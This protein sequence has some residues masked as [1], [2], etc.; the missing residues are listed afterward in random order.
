MNSHKSDGSGKNILMGNEMAGRLAGRYLIEN[1]CV[2][3]AVLLP[4]TLNPGL[5]SRIE[6]FRFEFFAN[7][8]SCNELEIPIR[9]QQKEL[10][11]CTDESLENAMEA[12]LSEERF[13]QYDG[14]FSPEERLTA[15]LYRALQ[16]RRVK[17]WPLIIS[18]NY[19]SEYLAGL[20]PRP[21]TI[22][23]GQRM[24]AELA[25]K[26]LLHRIS[27]ASKRDDNI[28]VIT[29]PKLVPGDRIL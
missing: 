29:T 15:F 13:Q 19:T 16:K 25:I 23:M 7:K 14:I 12:M 26:E 17:K 22:D 2:N 10:E 6:G 28:A 11:I 27:G 24:L 8:Y 5:A 3:S 9:A 18:C 21:A 4:P 1:H 20:Y